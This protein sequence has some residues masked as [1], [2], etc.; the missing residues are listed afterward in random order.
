MDGKAAVIIIGLLAAGG[1]VFSHAGG[2]GWD[3]S[4]GEAQ[5]AYDGHMAMHEA[6]HGYQGAAGW[7]MGGMMGMMQRS[8]PAAGM[9]ECHGASVTERTGRG[10]VE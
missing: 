6:H 1:V 2:T 7:G 5:A 10:V 8:G 9:G 3:F 4:G